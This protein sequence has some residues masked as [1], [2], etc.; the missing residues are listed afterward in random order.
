M[1][2]TTPAP[3]RGQASV[4]EKT[5]AVS[6]VVKV[7]WPEEKKMT[8]VKRRLTALW[9][10]PTPT[11]LSPRAKADQYTG[12]TLVRLRAPLQIP[13]SV[14]SPGIY[15]LRA[16]EGGADCSLAGI[17]NENETELVTTVTTVLDH[18]VKLRAKPHVRLINWKAC[19]DCGI[20]AQ[21]E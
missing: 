14:L 2:I 18:R 20:A 5:T 8:L 10:R 6:F 3:S 1:L 13:G 7:K 15:V 11:P 19:V 16:L 21:T 17:F 12:S 4:P 9:L